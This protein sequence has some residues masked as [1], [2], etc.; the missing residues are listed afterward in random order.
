MQTAFS[1]FFQLGYQHI[2]DIEGIDHLLFIIVLCATYRL[3]A[4][5]KVAILVTAFTIGHSITLAMAV[6]EV[7]TFPAQ[8]IEFLVPLTILLTA[9]YNLFLLKEKPNSYKYGLALFFGLIHGMAFSN[10]FKATQLP[11]QENQLWQQLLAFNLGVEV[12]QL[13]IVGGVLFTTYLMLNV[14]KV[15]QLSWIRGVSLFTIIMVAYLFYQLSI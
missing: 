3:K 14:L 13:L 1:T 6:G 2:L 5:K 4:W 10:F 7:L 11:E 12:G 9:L 15:R 8:I